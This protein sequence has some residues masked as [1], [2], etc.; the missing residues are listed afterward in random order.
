MD[1]WSLR[2]VPEKDIAPEQQCTPDPLHTM[3]STLYTQQS[4]WK[5][6]MNKQSTL[7]ILK[8][9]SQLLFTNKSIVVH[10]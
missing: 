2:K 4:R 7:A 10:K 3:L 5:Q 9:I 6:E 8:I 1:N